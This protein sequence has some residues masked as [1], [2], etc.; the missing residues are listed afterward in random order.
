MTFHKEDL[1]SDVDAIQIWNAKEL[2]NEFTIFLKAYAD[3][4]TEFNWEAR[5]KAITRMRGM[6]RGNAT[7]S[8]Y[9]EVFIPCMKQMID[10]IIKAVESLRTQ[11]A[12][13]ALSLIGDMGVFIGKHLDAYMTDQLLLCLFRCA[14]LTKKLVANASLETT[15]L[16][17]KHTP[18]YPKIMN[19][20]LLAMNEKNSQ[21]RLYT[22]T[23]TKALLQT[24]AH[25]DHTRSVM[26]RTNATDHFES[27]LAKG[28][29]DP[30]PAVKEIC[31]EAFW[32]F[33]EQWKTRGDHILKQLPAIAQKQLEKSK[34]KPSAGSIHPSP[35]LSPKKSNSLQSRSESAIPISPSNSSVISIH[36]SISPRAMSP[37]LRSFGASP[38]P[39]PALPPHTSI[40]SQLHR[41]LPSS[42]SSTTT[43]SHSHTSPPLVPSRT[44]TN[45][46]PRVLVRKK[47]MGLIKRKHLSLLS[48]L[49]S[50]DAL[51]RTEGLLQLVKRLRHQLPYNSPLPHQL[52]LSETLVVE[53]DTLK[54]ILV[55]IWDQS[56]DALS[57]WDIVTCVLLPLF[58]VEEVLMKAMSSSTTPGTILLYVKLFCQ[59]EHPNWVDFLMHSL[60]QTKPRL[61]PANRRKLM[62]IV[63]EWMDELLM[64]T[65]DRY[66]EVPSEYWEPKVAR[67]WFTSD[68]NIHQCLV[69]LVPLV[70]TSTTS[71][72]A[73][74]VS[75]LRHVRT[76]NEGLFD[77]TV[78][79]LL[80][81]EDGSSQAVDKLCRLLGIRIRPDVLFSGRPNVVKNN[82]SK[83]SSI[84]SNS[85]K[86]NNKVMSM[87]DNT[88]SPNNSFPLDHDGV[89]LMKQNTVNETAGSPPILRDDE[90]IFHQDTSFV[91]TTDAAVM[92]DHGT[93]AALVGP[94]ISSD[95]G[96]TTPSESP[97]TP[98]LPPTTDLFNNPTTT[99]DT[100][101]TNDVLD[102]RTVV[103]SPQPLKD[104]EPNL[105]RYPPPQHVPFFAPKKVTF[106]NRIFKENV[107]NE[108]G[109]KDKTAFLYSLMD[110]I[111]QDPINVFRKM[112]RLFREV[113][114]RRRWDQGGAEE[115]GSET[116]V[117]GG[118]SMN[119]AGNFVELVQRAILPYL[120]GKMEEERVT[121]L[122]L[123][124][125]RQLAVTQAGLFRF[126]ERQVDES[127]A[128]LESKIL[129]PLLEIRSSMNS[130]LRMAAEDALDAVLGTLS[131]ATTFELL[132]AYIVYRLVISPMEDIKE[133][134]RFHPVGSA[135]MYL[136]KWV[137]EINDA[138]YIDEWLNKGC[139]N[140]FFKGINHP[141]VHIR[142]SCVE[143]MVAF[144]EV[145]GDDL[146]LGL[147]DLRDDQLSLVRHYVGKSLKRKKQQNQHQQQQQ[148]QLFGI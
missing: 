148:Q 136:S 57:N 39:P 125:L 72:H 88:V 64:A 111:E 135:F 85:T 63:L 32:I 8:P 133:D 47:S 102:I 5:D 138:F 139:V 25:R 100:L 13:K 91:P 127:G 66:D 37:H 15:K 90:V 10:G 7:K 129:E 120:N 146:Y 123:E 109:A 33:Y 80:V 107:R 67:V 101:Y 14:S 97:V 128:S 106:W 134:S 70:L 4:E 84:V 144:H 52:Q 9:I 2:E 23:Y 75:V 98:V 121:V 118:R 122:G 69:L 49:Q 27:L 74:L 81:E 68:E 87:R 43:T 26:D 41:P 82:S 53:P 117:G 137:K 89:S 94:M 119:D 115:V 62:K 60:Q 114:I 35:I 96:T 65:D 142:K 36:R 6:L 73:A 112:N 42:S 143:A 116:W 126:Y 31:R 130:T 86:T 110:T 44:T 113:P 29:N 17:L 147:N 28:L 50:D 124:C 76:L 40:S 140:A 46:K 54:T 48:L 132:M 58:G 3:K 145:I 55:H 105:E 95:Y 61:S 78:V 34:S 108:T 19:M 59:V 21:V 71:W 12:V 22:M 38:P 93:Q 11:L 1:A 20:L 45:T 77:R 51:Q 18:F 131:P 30:T 83:T 79:T 141:F 104:S 103:P 99:T 92:D 56:P 16:F 24:H